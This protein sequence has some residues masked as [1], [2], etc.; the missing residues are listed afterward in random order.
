MAYGMGFLKKPKTRGGGFS[1][2]IAAAAAVGAAAAA[3]TRETTDVGRPQTLKRRQTDEEIIE[4][5]RK[6]AEVAKQQN[7]EDLHRS[8]WKQGSQYASAVNSWDRFHRQS[9]DVLATSGR[10]LGPSKP[11]RRPHGSSSGDDSDWESASEDE[12]SD[13]HS[14]LAYGHAEFPTPRPQKASVSKVG[15]GPAIFSTK[16]EDRKSSV[17]DPK[18]FGPCN[19]LRD[20]VNTPCGFDNG[21]RADKFPGAEEQRYT[22]SAE[23]ASF[24]ARPM[25]RVYP[26]Q[27]SDP[28]KIET[29]RASGSIVS[30]RPN[31]SNT[32]RDSIYSAMSANSR[33][34]PIPIQ[35]PKP[36]APVPSRIYEEEQIRGTE[37]SDIREP[38][39]RPTDSKTFA[40]TALVGAG[41][42][43]IGAAILAGRDKGK[44]PEPKHGRDERY[45]HDDHREDDTKVM[46]ARKAKELALEREIERLERALAGR[47]KARETRIRD[48]KRLSDPQPDELLERKKIEAEADKDKD[49]QHERERGRRERD[50]VQN[51]PYGHDSAYAVGEGSESARS[52]K[53]PLSSRVSEPSEQPIVVGEE[54]DEYRRVRDPTNPESKGRIDVFQFQVPDDSFGTGTTPLRAPSPIIIDVTPSPSPA[55]DQGRSSR[56]ES[57]EEEVRE[58]QHI[59]EETAHSTAPISE[60]A[61]AAAIAATEHHRRHHHGDEGRGRVVNKVQDDANR[62][63]RADRVARSRSKSS[64]ERSVVDKYKDDEGEDE[65]GRPPRIVTPPEMKGRPKK[66]Q[67]SEPDAD[68]LFDNKMSPIQLQGYWPKEAP[69]MD[70]SALRPRPVLNLVLPTPVPTPS[71]EKQEEKNSSKAPEPVKEG[72]TKGAAEVILGPK[73][74][75]VEVVEVTESPS[76]PKSVS[77]GPSETKQYEVDSRE[78]S[79]E[80]PAHTFETPKSSGKKSSSGWGVLASAITGASVG[81]ALAKNHDSESRRDEKSKGILE[82]NRTSGSRSPPKERPIL[83]TGIHSHVL[84]EEPEEL[85]PAP[86]PKP[87]SPRNSQ[88]PGAFGEDLDFTATLAAGLEHSGFDPEIV[89]ENPEYRRRDSPPGSNEPFMGVYEQPFAETMT[90]LGTFDIDDGSRP[91]HEPG[92]VLG[93][94]A[95]TPSSEKAAPFDESDGASHRKGKKRSSLGYE[96][97]DIVGDTEDTGRDVPKLSKKEQRKLD[98]AAKTAKL[99]DE[100]EQATRPIEV[101]EHEWAEVPTAM[102]SKKSKKS[103]RASVTWEDADTPVSDT[104]V[105]VPVDSFDDIKDAADAGDG[106]DTPKTSKKSKRDSKGYDLLVDDSPDKRDRRKDR[107]EPLDRDSSSVVYDSKYDDRSNG[108]SRDD[109]RSVVP[110]PSGSD[111]TADSKSEKRSSGSSFW[112][113][114]TGSSNDDD[115]KESKKDSAGTLGAGAGLAGVAVAIAALARS[116][117]VD[118]PSN[119]GELHVVKDVDLSDRRADSSSREVEAFEDPEIVPRVIKPAI[120]PQYGDLLPLP[121]SPGE[122]SSLDFDEGDGESLPALPDSRPAT[123]PGRERALLRERERESGQKPPSHSRRTSVFETPLRSPSHTAIPIQFRMGHRSLPAS[124]PTVGSR[125]SPTV[126]GHSSPTIQSPSASGQEFSPTF[127]RQ[128]SRPTSWDS[129]KE[130]KPLYLLEQ[131]GGRSTRGDETHDEVVETTPMP[132]ATDLSTQEG[133]VSKAK[134]LPPGVADTSLFIDTNVAHSAPVESQES[135]PRGAQQ[136]QQELPS[137]T[138]DVETPPEIPT[139]SSLPESSYATPFE[140]PSQP[141]GLDPS[142]EPERRQAEETPS[143]RLEPETEPVEGPIPEASAKQEKKSYFQSAFSILPAATLAGV[144]VLL[145]RGKHGETHETSNDQVNDTDPPE[146]LS[147]SADQIGET[148]GRTPVEP[149]EV[150][151]ASLSGADEG[152]HPQ[153]LAAEFPDTEN[154]E[155][156][157]SLNTS[158]DDGLDLA[159]T[160]TRT[161]DKGIIP[162]APVEMDE[163]TVQTGSSKKKKKKGKKKQSVSDSPQISTTA[164]ANTLDSSDLQQDIS[165][166]DRSV[167]AMM[168][169]PTAAAKDSS[170]TSAEAQHPVEMSQEDVWDTQADAVPADTIDML[171]PGNLDDSDLGQRELNEGPA[172]TQSEI[173]HGPPINQGNIAGDDRPSSIGLVEEPASNMP[174]T[175]QELSRYQTNTVHGASDVPALPVEE[176]FQPTESGEDDWTFESSKEGEKNKKSQNVNLAEGM[177]ES[178]LPKLPDHEDLVGEP[179]SSLSQELP[180]PAESSSRDMG[181]EPLEASSQGLGIESTQG[182]LQSQNRI[183]PA[184][185]S[186]DPAPYPSASK[187]LE[188]STR[189]A[190][191]QPLSVLPIEQVDEQ[192]PTA[193]QH[194]A[195]EPSSILLGQSGLGLQEVEATPV[196]AEEEFPFISKKSKKN[197]KKRKGS[198]VIDDAIQSSGTATTSEQEQVEGPSEVPQ[199]PTSTIEEKIQPEMLSSGSKSPPI[200]LEDTQAFGSSNLGC[201]SPS[202]ADEVPVPVDTMEQPVPSNPEELQP[203]LLPLENS[204]LTRSPTQEIQNSM[205]ENVPE[206][207]ELLDAAREQPLVLGSSRSVEPEVTTNETTSEP[208]SSTLELVALPAQDD[209]LVDY[210]TPVPDKPLVAQQKDTEKVLAEEDVAHHEAEAIRYQ[211]EDAELARLQLK[212]KPSKKDKQRLKELRV[213]AGQRAEE[214]Q[215][216]SFSHVQAPEETFPVTEEVIRPPTPTSS[217]VIETTSLA[218]GEPDSVYEG[219]QSNTVSD[220]QQPDLQSETL[221]QT[222]KTLLGSENL[223]STDGVTRGESHRNADDLEDPEEVAR[224]EAKTALI[225][226]E[227]AELARIKIKR[228]PSKKDKDRIK[229][230]KANA[231]RRDREAEAVAQRQLGEKAVDLNQGSS[232]NSPQDISHA[233]FEEAH[234]ENAG[235]SQPQSN[236]SNQP[237]SNMGSA[238]QAQADKTMVYQRDVGADQDGDIL[239]SGRDEVSQHSEHQLDQIH[240]S[241]TQA[242]PSSP[243]AQDTSELQ[244]VEEVSLHPGDRRNV[245]DEEMAQREEQAKINEA[246]DPEPEPTAHFVLEDQSA[247]LDE[248]VFPSNLEE[249]SSAHVQESLSTPGIVQEQDVAKGTPTTESQQAS[250]SET[251]PASEWFVPAKKSKKDKKKKRKGTLSED[252]GQNSGLVTPIDENEPVTAGE[253]VG[254]AEIPSSTSQMDTISSMSH[255]TAPLEPMEMTLSEQT[256]SAAS[257]SQSRILAEEESVTRSAL[258]QPLSAT[259]EDTMHRGGEDLGQT[260]TLE[261]PRDDSLSATE[262]V[263]YVSWERTTGPSSGLEQSTTD[264]ALDQP[265]AAEQYPISSTQAVESLPSPGSVSAQDPLRICELTQDQEQEPAQALEARRDLPLETQL[266]TAISDEQQQQSKD[267]EHTWTPSRKSKKD[268]KKKHSSASWVEPDSGVQT[269]SNEKMDEPGSRDVPPETAAIEETSDPMQSLPQDELPA[270]GLDVQQQ[271]DDW[272]TAPSRK[273]KDK[274]KKKWSSVSSWTPES[275]TH[276]PLYDESGVSQDIPRSEF[277]VSEVP[278]GGLDTHPVEIIHQEPASLPEP[279]LMAR[280]ITPLALPEKSVPGPVLPGTDTEPDVAEHNIF[281]E[282]ISK[283]DFESIAKDGDETLNVAGGVLANDDLALDNEQDTVPEAGWQRA[284]AESPQLYEPI[285]K[286]ELDDNVKDG[287]DMIIVAG[288]KVPVSEPL[289][290]QHPL[291]IKS[292]PAGLDVASLPNPVT[293]SDLESEVKNGED[294][295]TV[296]GGQSTDEV[297]EP[298]AFEATHGSHTITK[299]DLEAKV[300]DGEHTLIIAGGDLPHEHIQPSQIQH[301]QSPSEPENDFLDVDRA[302][303]RPQSPIP[304]EDEDRPNSPE[305]DTYALAVDQNFVRPES[306]VPWEDNN[307]MEAFVTPSAEIPVLADEMQPVLTSSPLQ[308]SEEPFEVVSVNNGKKD[309]EEKKRGS[310]SQSF[311]HELSAVTLAPETPQFEDAIEQ[312]P[313]RESLDTSGPTTERDIELSTEHFDDWTPKQPS[314]EG[315]RKA[316]NDPVPALEPETIAMPAGYIGK[317]P[318]NEM[319]HQAVSADSQ[320]LNVAGHDND[321]QTDRS[322]SKPGLLRETNEMFAPIDRPDHGPY[323]HLRSPSTE[324]HELSNQEPLTEAAPLSKADEVGSSIDHPQE[325]D[326]SVTEGAKVQDIPI[327]TRKMSKKE[328]R[329]AKKTAASAWEDDL[330][331]TSQTLSSAAVDTS[332]KDILTPS[333]P[334]PEPEMTEEMADISYPARLQAKKDGAGALE[335]VIATDAVAEDE[336]SVPLSRKK[337]KKDKKKKGKQITSEPTSGLQPPFTEEPPKPT[338]AQ[339]AGLSSINPVVDEDFEQS[340]EH[341]SLPT[342]LVWAPSTEPSKAS[343]GAQ[344]DYESPVTLG[345]ELRKIPSA[346]T[347]PDIWDNED[348]FKPKASGNSGLDPSDQ[349][350]DKV[351]IHPA[352][353]QGLKTTPDKG[354]K[355]DRP[356]VGLGL[357]HRHSS[358]FQEDDHHIPKLLTTASDNLSVESMAVEDVE[359]SDVPSKPGA[360]LP[361]GTASAPGSS[362]MSHDEPVD[363]PLKN[364]EVFNINETPA[365]KTDAP[366]VRDDPAVNLNELRPSLPHSPRPSLDESRE[367]FNFDDVKQMTK[368]GSVA[369]IAEKFGG[370]KKGSGK[371]KKISKYVDKRTPQE[372]DIFDEPAMWEGAERKPVEGSRLDAD[373]GDFWTVQDSQ[374]EDEE[375]LDPDVHPGQGSTATSHGKGMQFEDDN[376]S[377]THSPPGQDA[378]RFTP[379]VPEQAVREEE[380]ALDSLVLE[381]P[382]LGSQSSFEMP[383][384][385]AAIE[386][387]SPKSSVDVDTS[388]TADQPAR[389]VGLALDKPQQLLRDS[390]IARSASPSSDKGVTFQQSSLSSIETEDDTVRPELTPSVVLRRSVSRGLP[391]VREEPQEEEAESGKHASTFHASTP[392][393]NRDSGFVTGSPM[394]P[395]AHRFDDAQQR[396]SGVHLRDYPGTSPRLLSSRGVSPEPSRHSRSSLEDE[397]ARLDDGPRRSPLAQ[398]E[399]GRRIREGTPILEAREA[400]VTPEPQKGRVVEPRSHKYPG[401]GLGAT[402]TTTAAAAAALLAGARP[403]ATSPSPPASP[404]ASK[405]SV[406]DSSADKN[407]PSA[408]PNDSPPSQ[409]RA[410]SNTGI[411][412]TRTPEPLNL[413]PDS[414]SLLRHSATPPLRSRRTR[415]GDL[416]SLSQSSQRSRSDLG[417]SASPSSPALAPASTSRTATG[418]PA[419][420]NT[421][422]PASSSSSSDLRRATT[423]ASAAQPST[424]IPIANEG[425]VR[426]KDM[427]DVYVSRL[428]S[429]H[430]QLPVT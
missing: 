414:P 286:A 60:I 396:D 173:V 167:P 273:G 131:A 185:L 105:S 353:A 124:S 322:L 224:R 342:S 139:S 38:R 330:L 210:S 196:V 136:V 162:E 315:E 430:F 405:R 134:V 225:Q 228:K 222:S 304:W 47:N 249:S 58:A 394:L 345:T 211:E 241:S 68:V 110:A 239:P 356:L 213:K 15:T 97:I 150:K 137:P 313:L 181:S 51:E 392:D 307:P 189:D 389:P 146:S 3:I 83:S 63:Y 319:A 93:E 20:F 332:T 168:E 318:M 59:C 140:Y 191:T 337:S 184:I 346:A 152:G 378:G 366:L 395:W 302:T 206:E 281:S 380:V 312:Q 329:K 294:S 199:Q 267:E 36:I 29:V 176:R 30:A 207:F 217:R 45:G 393:M 112:G 4:I 158:H 155:T 24:E 296:A 271:L 171:A 290:E 418:T 62:T 427:A 268:K 135:T 400:P 205:S 384:Q 9:S 154:V 153:S 359:P 34:D 177:V 71:P 133:D 188:D 344:I 26:V 100:E 125:S 142:A 212:R 415:S 355:D 229:V 305:R 66:G 260:T 92:Y 327:L 129:S 56:R 391:P 234:L 311:D 193:S 303:M 175:L 204:R 354:S 289:A 233:I 309:R 316:E 190:L 143:P 31:H 127:K 390:P 269:P 373:A 202:P 197:K 82:D 314:K 401:L 275:S 263:Q 276:T 320:D 244:R 283:P 227:E 408:F 90:D 253:P 291:G 180:K 340:T 423:P 341:F 85:P 416:R 406:S 10:G 25:Q 243:P 214:A 368:K 7:R 301:R 298:W 402:A 192:N 399:T 41:V 208:I 99:A 426:S 77:W 216:A 145:G 61:L 141:L 89:I 203:D 198:T 377:A 72:P 382:V 64:R 385:E 288:G 53:R 80:R 262:P 258:D 428:H 215:A 14:A 231:E 73:G 242:R 338:D 157:S 101:G 200:T 252:S 236:A 411:S 300:V 166:Q 387:H 19:S 255:G 75:V 67:Y 274:K 270:H 409:R 44:A 256:E 5:G 195:E 250:T 33:P 79:R 57:F 106:W 280:E 279:D 422:A 48:S 49:Y 107:Y 306:P 186:E 194:L 223:P 349:P 351:E 104:R 120:D 348:Y 122:K 235:S 358:I 130:I 108:H 27:T 299:S 187:A 371:K 50:S 54:D 388:Q 35:A 117:A 169:E 361:T 357:I 94:V 347:S 421:P 335:T 113:L 28:D 42:A 226:E 218:F 95:D 404:A 91:V 121:P 265:V 398:S 111:P 372:D 417:A 323:T 183:D 334:P 284:A 248:A 352:F 246:G 159:G 151:L 333:D 360:S 149:S 397:G 220:S 282:P 237:T 383:T 163:R 46:D 328:K 324:Q 88:M 272:S 370:T 292:H 403:G 254:M 287:D 209:L 369:T 78:G 11:D 259:Q 65:A 16:L 363:S 277:G 266:S 164:E 285:E 132:L 219:N 429:I 160:S 172:P 407:R 39:R 128:Q 116:D 115:T 87:S 293:K 170:G 96:G 413:R 119:Q 410:V 21:S 52:Y 424:N 23:S 86:G 118:A 308:I 2:N 103:K 147:R 251:Q 264:T 261:D 69:V 419:A 381:S 295:L 321:L 374:L 240:E 232:Q 245:G 317:S 109:A 325:P 182:D 238:S 32:P 343:S 17:V 165:I 365:Q 114:I 257:P 144:G 367:T 336:W 221:G 362:N 40:E 179:D 350:F 43:A 55:P 74:D 420:A 76:T 339:M 6:L 230:L 174:G 102:K 386:T 364:D 201:T 70:P 326:T 375:A 161:E 178:P 12:D 412:R 18:L 98:K 425:R 126:G 379:Q 156:L 278:G 81:A 22:G 331:E 84:T 297:S 376:V 1:P 37:P 138:R 148:S 13:E 8:G 310:T 247:Q 123:P